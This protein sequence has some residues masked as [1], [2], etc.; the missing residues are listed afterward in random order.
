MC[1]YRLSLPSSIDHCGLLRNC[2]RAFGISEGFGAEFLSVLE[3]CIHEAFVNAA[4]HGNGGDTAL[5]VCVTMRTMPESGLAPLQVEVADC[6]PGFELA[7]KGVADA[8]DCESGLSGRGVA[9]ILHYAES[10]RL[11]PLSGGS[12]LRLTYIPF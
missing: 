3:L 1:L 6:G 11:E 5:P 12:V 4:M 10:A 8:A 7:S 9:I 2:V